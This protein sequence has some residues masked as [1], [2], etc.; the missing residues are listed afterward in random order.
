MIDRDDELP[1]DIHQRVKKLCASGDE[2]ASR[3]EFKN[4]VTSYQRALELLPEPKSKWEAAAW[5][6]AAIGDA[7]FLAGNMRPALDAI[8]MAIGS[9][10]GFGNAFL[11]LR[12]GQAL[13]ELGRRDEAANELTRAY[14]IAGEQ[15]FENEHPKYETFLEG[16]LRRSAK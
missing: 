9:A 13:F 10:T 3:R 5:I 1:D 4:A 7:Y 12:R 2:A 14:A 16:V 15:I 11:H 6:F 8:N